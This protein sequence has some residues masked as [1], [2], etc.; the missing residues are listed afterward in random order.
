MK[1]DP[2]AQYGDHS[3]SSRRVPCVSACKIDP[4]R[5][6]IG[7]QNWPPYLRFA[8]L[9]KRTCRLRLAH[10]EIER[11][12]KKRSRDVRRQAPQQI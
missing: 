9:M 1:S 8:P 12:F 4:L 6:V 7:V 2:A 3:A 10:N 5:G 11:P